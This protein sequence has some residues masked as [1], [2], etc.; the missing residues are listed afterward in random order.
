MQN[1]Q[2]N[3]SPKK[4]PIKQERA[5]KIEDRF[6]KIIIS[7]GIAF[8]LYTVLP[9]ESRL[10]K[11]IDEVKESQKEITSHYLECNNKFSKLEKDQSEK[12]SKEISSLKDWVLAMI[13]KLK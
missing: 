8:L 12:L 1:N 5:K 10:V 2:N 7:A 9:M 13:N 11:E 3:K 6:Y 4:K